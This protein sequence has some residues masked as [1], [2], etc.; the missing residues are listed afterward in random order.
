MAQ[1]EARIPLPLI[2][3]D[4]SEGDR[5]YY[6]GTDADLTD[7]HYNF[8]TVALMKPDCIIMQMDNGEEK[9]LRETA[10]SD[11]VSL[12]SGWRKALNLAELEE[13]TVISRVSHG[14]TTYGRVIAISSRGHFSLQIMDPDKDE[15]LWTI[16]SYKFDATSAAMF[17][18]WEIEP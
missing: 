16:R 1:E 10:A 6:V 13:G 11:F 2:P 14:E 9:I 4:L 17:A 15:G 8:G 3:A 12:L 7:P 5:V 18:H